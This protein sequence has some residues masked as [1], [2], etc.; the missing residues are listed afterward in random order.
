LTVEIFPARFDAGD[1]EKLL[2]D[3]VEVHPASVT[4]LFTQAT[5]V[6]R[7][8]DGRDRPDSRQKVG[9][10]PSVTEVLMTDMG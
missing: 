10:L 7:Q 9:N 6:R 1:S 8:A 5:T 2:A 4:R 3:R